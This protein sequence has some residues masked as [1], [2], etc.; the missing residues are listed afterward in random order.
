[1]MNATHPNVSTNLYCFHCV[2]NF[3][4]L[5]FFLN[6][7]SLFLNAFSVP[8]KRGTFQLQR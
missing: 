2:L 8:F 1:M 5:Y 6:A 7:F 4:V 3:N